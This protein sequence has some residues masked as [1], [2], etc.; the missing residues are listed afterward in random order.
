LSGVTFST[1]RKRAEVPGFSMSRTWFW[2]CLSIPDFSSFPKSAPKPAPTAI[3][4]TGTKNRIPKSIP[5]NMPQVAPAPT[6]WWFVTTLYLPSLLQM[7]AAI[8]S[9]WM[10]SSSARCSASFIASMA[11]VSLS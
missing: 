5:Q 1:T 11:V 7:I 10:I 8:A 2:N 3:P 9:G 4:S 6:M